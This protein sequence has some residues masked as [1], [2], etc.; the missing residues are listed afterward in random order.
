LEV[1]AGTTV[2]VS[3]LTLTAG[4]ADTGG[5]VQNAGTLTLTDCVITGNQ[6][7]VSFTGT[8]T[9]T[10]QAQGGGIWTS[11][12]LTLLRCSVSDNTAN[13]TAGNVY[14]GQANGG[15]LYATGASVTLVNSTVS[16]NFS[17]S[18]FTGDAGVVFAYG[19]GLSSD[20]GTL[21]LT[22][23]TVNGNTATGGNGAG[24]GGGVHSYQSTVSLS[25][26]TVANNLATSGSDSGLGGGVSDLDSNLTLTS[27]TIT[28]NVA[29]SLPSTGSGGGLYYNSGA[30]SVQV[31]NTIVAGN[32]AATDG[33]DVSGNFVSQ[34]YN[35]IGIT[36]GSTGWGG[37]D[38]TGTAANPLDPMLGTLGSYGGPTQT[39]PLLAGSPA[40]DAGDPAQLG[41]T[42]QRGVARS[43]G[44]NIGAFQASAASFV[45]SAPASA[46]AGVPFEVS[47]AVYD[48]FGQVAVGYSGTIHF[49][50]TDG[51]PNVVL[52]MDY[53]FGIGNGGM[54]T[55]SGG[56]TLI[57]SG[58]Q[59]LTATDLTSGTTGSVIVML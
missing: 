40:L 53:T 20:N 13:L 51:D 9:E 56:V 4:I 59:T 37:S 23:C 52:P 55:F 44:V 36:D 5:G 19:G 33:P 34:G 10:A 18:T 6:A 14:Y 3:G 17:T 49:S 39:I 54:V 42:D 1:F 48:S 25:N 22:G 11:G 16:G 28:G 43:G 50:T 30:G 21:N 46:T 15:G 41:T 26:C 2:S 7:A 12:A 29:S 31:D 24:F 47:V 38:L 57:T 45:V 35:L 58:S 27:C 32:T 8:G